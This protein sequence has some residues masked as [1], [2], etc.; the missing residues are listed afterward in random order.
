MKTLLS[1]SFELLEIDEYNT[2]KIYYD[3]N[4]HYQECK[5]LTVRKTREA[6]KGMRTKKKNKKKKHKKDVKKEIIKIEKTNIILPK[7]THDLLLKMSHINTKIREDIGIKIKLH[8]VLTYQMG[9]NRKGCINR[10]RNATKNI[11][12]I[13]KSLLLSNEIPIAF[14]RSNKNEKVTNLK[15]NGHKRKCI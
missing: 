5:N 9:N 6:K 3:D 7:D 1:N 13:V 11:M 8:S 15:S 10:D 2:S 14:Q 4:K 12:I